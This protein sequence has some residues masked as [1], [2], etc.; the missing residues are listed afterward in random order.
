MTGMTSQYVTVLDRELH[1][2]E[3]GE[4]GRDAIVMWH[5]LARTCRDFDDL[6]KSLA[7]RYRVI[8]PDTI[9]RGLSQ[10]SPQP[11]QEYSLNFYAALAT[12]LVDALG[13][14][15]LRWIGTSMGGAP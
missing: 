7:D 2:V 1:Y 8:C 4:R 9:G 14:G 15:R 6:A 13:I 10:W 11:E 3:W 5:G 12:A